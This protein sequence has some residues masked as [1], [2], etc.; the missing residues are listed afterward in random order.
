MSLITKNIDGT[1]AVHGANYDLCV[2]GHVIDV[3]IDNNIY[4]SLDVRCAAPKTNEAKD[5][6]I[7]DG[8][9]NLPTLKSAEEEPGKAVFVWENT[10]A[11]WKKEYTLTC[12]YMRFTFHVKLIGSGAVDGIRYFSGDMESDTEFGSAYEFSEGFNPCYA[13]AEAEKQIFKA[14]EQCHRWSVLMVPPMFCYAFRCEGLSRRLGLGLCAQRGEHNFHSF[15]YHVRGSG[16]MCRT[17]FWLETDQAGHVVVDGEWTAPH[18]L[19]LA[20]EDQFDVLRQ[21]SEYY[22]DSGIATP[23]KNEI[24]PRFW[25][26]PIV[27]GWL[28]Q[29]A[30]GVEATEETYDMII[31]K[32]KRYDLHPKVMIIDDK[33]QLHYSND[34]ADPAHFSDMRAFTDR[35]HADGINTILWF[36]LFDGEGWDEDVCLKAGDDILV[37]P[38]HPKFKEALAANIH[39]LLSSEEGCYN[40]DGFKI[41][42]AFLNPIGREVKTYSGKYGVELLYEYQSDI[43]NFAKAVKPYAL[44]NASPAH[45]YFAHITDHGRVHDYEPKNRNNREDLTMRGKMFSLAMPGVILDTDNAG[46][47]SLRDTMRWMLNQNTVGVPDLYSV[48]STRC[49]PFTDDDFAAIAEVWRNYSARIDAKYE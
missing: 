18:I 6:Y 24:P 16:Y 46:F 44:I 34:M 19:G 45:P 28:E 31:E 15:D 43:Y 27:C 17:G 2:R 32:C 22:F 25:Y 47:N 40:C 5:G 33:W 37:D 30:N 38:S 48:T 49:C 7:P 21:Y 29:L 4:A 23:R 3:K 14:S 41:D 11:L 26:G 10:S 9:S 39:R 12:T 20:G 13:W 1:H 8:E 35:R 42:F 36:K